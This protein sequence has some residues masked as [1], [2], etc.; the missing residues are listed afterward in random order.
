MF[1]QVPPQTRKNYY[2]SPR[3]YPFNGLA[4]SDYFLFG[5]RLGFPCYWING[6]QPGG[7]W[8]CSWATV[9]LST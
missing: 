5:F 2:S 1:E 4:N 6:V 9:P 7:A 3:G 8:E